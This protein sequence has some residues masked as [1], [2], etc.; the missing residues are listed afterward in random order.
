MSNLEVDVMEGDTFW[1]VNGHAYHK[2]GE[3]VQRIGLQCI[4]SWGKGVR[5]VGCTPLDFPTFSKYCEGCGLTVKHI[6]PEPVIET[7]NPPEF[8]LEWNDGG[9]TPQKDQA[10][11]EAKVKILGKKVVRVV[12]IDW[13][14]L[15]KN[16]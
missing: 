3:D 16:S 8:W 10:S 9:Y 15:T 1:H 12:R 14:F 5:L 13:S 11:G 7:I 6:K 2:R 4:S